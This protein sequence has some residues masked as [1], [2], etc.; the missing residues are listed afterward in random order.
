MAEDWIPAKEEP[1]ADA[2]AEPPLDTPEEEGQSPQMS[3][4]IKETGEL[5]EQMR[6]P[7]E[8][9]AEEAKPEGE[10]KP[11]IEEPATPKP[12]EDTHFIPDLDKASPEQIKARLDYLYGK[13]KENQRQWAEAKEILRKER[14]KNEELR[15][16]VAKQTIAMS[17]A[18][19]DAQQLR[20]VDLL[21]V[22]SPN[23]N[24]QEGARQLREL[25]NRDIQVK[26]EK[27]A[28]ERRGEEFK[29]TLEQE[30]SQ[31]TLSETAQIITDWSQTRAYAQEGHP[32][33]PHV[34]EWLRKA[35]HEAPA[36][37]TVQQ[38]VTKAQQV[39]DDYVSKG[40]ATT[41]QPAN[42]GDRG[43]PKPASA[44]PRMT[45]S[46]VIGTQQRG[47]QAPVSVAEKLSAREREIALKLFY[48]PESGMT[49]EK[50]YSMYAEGKD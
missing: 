7:P 21:N 38:I 49:R 34:V 22:N 35:Y 40:G 20:V 13:D 30:Q 25:T 4:F 44:S 19:L 3:A 28:E 48:N 46:Q 8:K 24:P 50:A 29:T 36:N 27:Q 37:V 18:E 23:Y 15:A 17:E 5:W 10:A 2:P 45:V 26:E 33:Y 6:K 12:K 42:G 11:K 43:A 41:A 1:A 47:S 39:F 16:R 14:E 32:L 9:P 31:A